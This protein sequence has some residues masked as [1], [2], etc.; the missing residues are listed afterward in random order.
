MEL[1]I[2]LSSIIRTTIYLLLR[3]LRF[4]RDLHVNVLLTKIFLDFLL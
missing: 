1:G 3:L 2:N 4:F